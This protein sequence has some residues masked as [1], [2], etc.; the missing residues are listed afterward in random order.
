MELT[1]Q[2]VAL[3]E[4]TEAD[5]GPDPGTTEYADAD[6]DEMASAV[7]AKHESQHLRE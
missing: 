3:V 5:P 4:R 6:F 2:L 7:L 1:A